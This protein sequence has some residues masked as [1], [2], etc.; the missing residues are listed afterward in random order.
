[1]PECEKNMKKLIPLFLILISAISY[2]QNTVSSINGKVTDVYTK[3]GLPGVNIVIPGSKLGASTDI[4]G[5]YKISNVAI[6]NYQ[7]R[8]SAIGYKTQTKTD[9]FVKTVKSAIVDFEMQ[10]SSVELEGVTASAGYFQKDPY[11]LNS[12]TNF[13]FEEIR[14][15]PGGYEDVI[16]AVSI[17]PGV[18]QADAGRNDL[19]V[20]GGAPSE[21]L[22]LVDGLA[23]PNINH[24]GSQGATGGPL[25]Y[26]NLDFVKETSFSTGG[27]SSMHGDKLSSV[28]EINLREG[29]KD[30]LGGKATI[31]ATQFGLNAEGPLGEKGDFIFS[32]RR[33]YLD[34]IF[35]AA[36]FGFVPEYYDF[37][38]KANYSLD[39]KNTLSYLFIGAFDNVRYFNDTQ[40][41]RYSNA[42]AL[43]SDQQ[44]YVTGISWKN[45]FDNGFLNVS[46]SRNY[47]DFNTIQRDTMLN[48]IFKNESMESENNLT[49][50]LI[51]KLGANSEL[52]IGTTT[53][54]IKFR[55]DI[56]L[57]IFITT[58]GDTLKISSL[59]AKDNFYKSDFYIQYSNVLFDHLRVNI[60]ARLDYFNAINTKTFISPRLS[61]SYMF[62]EITNINFST[63]I[64]RQSPSYLWLIADETNKNLKDLRVDQYILGFD[65]RLRYDVIAKVEGFYKNYKDYPASVLRRYLVLS[66][67]GAGY[68]GAED[69]FSSFGLEPLVS[70]GKGFARGVELSLQ[71]KSSD[72]P[73]YGL[74]SLTY[75][76][77][78]YTALDG[79]ERRGSYEQNWIMN[80]GAGWIFNNK[81]E[82]SLKFRF[83]TGKPYTPYNSD[84]TQDI[85]KYNTA[86]V[87]ANHS[88]DIRIDRKWDL[89]GYNLIAYIDIQNIYNRKNSS[90]VRWDQRER[91][92]I[93]AS[94]IGILPS[95]GLSLEM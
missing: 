23:I 52:G 90:F 84:G 69:N 92:E 75:S 36:G 64:Y 46:L 86:K 80:L 27:F 73:H 21:N 76:E 31:A 88:L 71:K 54:L 8:A 72:V 13:S 16:R 62:N 57:P 3:Q 4:N 1:M 6:G 19:I 17:L 18:A 87:I 63:G 60:G 15:A 7:V 20:R 10:E 68:A 67:T 41:K 32:A 61:L 83:A 22:Y 82:G 59:N 66:N 25:S 93:S 11:E 42:R 14:R 81:W 79:I 89:S 33:S 9:I 70:G 95:I 53:K 29:R 2:S 28:L 50:D 48:P 56:K 26:I 38:T 39:N 94:T 5:E 30:R 37:M 24:F 78:R 55:A 34:F 65:H 35:K 74:F 77:S 45:L 12:V 51:Y 49:A 58:F 43:G 91:K 85:E 44:Q 40:D 47:T